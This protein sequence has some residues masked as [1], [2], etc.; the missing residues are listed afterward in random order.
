MLMKSIKLVAV[1]HSRN[2][3][4]YLF[5]APTKEVI[6]EGDD[7]QVDTFRGM[8]MGKAIATLDVLTG[9]DAYNFIIKATGAK[10]PLR[11]VMARY[12]RHEMDYPEEDLGREYDEDYD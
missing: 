3:G 7:V 5:Y 4:T 11:R 8:E 2:S 10:E 1:K 9:T 12:E 6:A